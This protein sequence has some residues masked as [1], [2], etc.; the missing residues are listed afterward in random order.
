MIEWNP[1]P[2][3]YGIMSHILTLLLSLTVPSSKGLSCHPD[4]GLAFDSFTVCLEK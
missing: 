4:T 1:V 3:P 2:Y